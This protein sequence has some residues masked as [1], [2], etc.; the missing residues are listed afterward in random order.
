MCGLAGFVGPG[1]RGDLAAMV[2]ALVHRGPDDEGTFVDE[3]A[4]V[5]LGHRRLSVIDIAGGHQ[6]MWN[7]DRSVG[8][9]YNGEVYNFRELRHELE[10]EG[11]RFVSDHSDTEVVLRGYEA[12]GDG[13]VERLNGMFAFAIYDVRRRRIFCARDRFGEKP[14]YYRHVGGAFAFAS[15]LTALTRYPDCGAEYDTLALQKLFAHGFV[16][17]PN[18]IYRDCRKLPAGCTLDYD[19]ATGGLNVSRY[20][21]FLLD[22]DEALTDGDEGRL[23]EELRALITQAVDRRMVSDVP[24][25]IFLSGGID[26]STILASAAQHT[27]GDD[28]STYTIGFE[29]PTYD[30]SGEAREVASLFATDHHCQ[31]LDLRRARDLIPDILSAMDEPIGDPS[32]LP[33]SMLCAYTRRHVTVALSGDGG[34]ELFAGYDPFKAL[35]PAERYVRTIPKPLHRGFRRLVELLPISDRNMSL[36]FKLRRALAGVSYER[37]FWNPVWLGPVEPRDLPDLIHEPVAMEDLFSEVLGV[38]EK[39]RADN[40]VDRTLEFYTNFYLQDGILTKTDRAA[41][42][43]SLES[44]AVFLDNDLVSFCRRLPGRFKMRDGTRK[45]LLRKAAA[46]LLPD[47]VLNRRKKGFGIPVSAWLKEFPVEAPLAPIDG[48]DT[49]W[50]SD[51]WS[52]H[53]KGS[54]DNRLFLWTWMALQMTHGARGADAV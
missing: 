42:S 1:D 50:A 45:Y 37:P 2:S 13:F 25:G 14:F 11:H 33:T 34:D 41:M 22:P 28:L 12:W 24:L 8:I 7:P 21:Q 54:E 9:V 39:S 18:T 32:I 40:M 38:W 17:A 15:E 31:V 52:A 35:T 49:G 16:P 48:L 20:W 29:E 19:L 43:H 27:A 10:A 4:S 53:R 46:G 6:P 51:R 3:A 44:R 5:F 36:D 26:S 47:R 23:V 30:E